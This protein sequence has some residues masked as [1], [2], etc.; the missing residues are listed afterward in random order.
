MKKFKVLGGRIVK[1][2]IAVFLTSLICQLLNWPAVFA[3]ITAIVT[4]EPTAADSIKKGLIRLPASA[5]GSAYAVL[6]IFLFGNSPITYTAAAVFT[7]VT[8][9]RLK[10]H[11]GLLVATLTSVAMIEVI[12]SNYLISFFIRLGTTSIGLLVSTA[13]NMFVYPPNYS[14]LILKNIHSLA[15]TTGIELENILKATLNGQKPK[16]KLIRDTF[17][18]LK[19]RLDKTEM[20]IRFQKEE[21][22]Y[23]RFDEQAKR[24]F[25]SEQEKLAALRLI[26]YHIGNLINTPLDTLLW[27]TE[28][29][30]KVLETVECLAAALKNSDKFNPEEHR[31]QIQALMAQF[32]KSKKEA[33]KPDSTDHPTFFTS[34]IIILY[35]LLSIYNLVEDLLKEEATSED[36]P[37]PSNS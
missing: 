9:F 19:R 32:W 34:E 1:T 17:S 22:K 25:L 30:E 31:R 12:H 4:I 18:Q 3:V 35:E 16:E 8:C 28:E 26:H 15:R 36:M 23:H 20:L 27:S 7:I 6:F 33:A 29:K 37:S 2:G 5:I 24:V 10:L 21:S 11:S 14:S 13:V